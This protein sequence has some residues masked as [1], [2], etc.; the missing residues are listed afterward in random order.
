MLRGGRGERQRE[1]QVTWRGGGWE[2]IPPPGPGLPGGKQHT[3]GCH[4]MWHD[5]CD[6]EDSSG[7]E[8]AA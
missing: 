6:T 7:R 5:S 3:V 4:G 1:A 8:A 2:A